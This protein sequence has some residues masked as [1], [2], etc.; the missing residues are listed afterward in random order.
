MASL[1]AHESLS[2]NTVIN[3][4]RAQLRDVLPN[5]NEQ[6]IPDQV[7]RL[8]QT[9]STGEDYRAISTDATGG[10]GYRTNSSN[11]TGDGSTVDDMIVDI[12][13]LT[14]LIIPCG[15][16]RP[17]NDRFRVIPRIFS[18]AVFRSDIFGIFPIN[19]DRFLSESI[20]NL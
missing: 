8:W 5:L 14:S 4:V 7:V 15:I 11:V 13:I 16:V 18:E 17:G 9:I 20:G 1:N 3:H 6:S 2:F 19:S 12:I 10:G